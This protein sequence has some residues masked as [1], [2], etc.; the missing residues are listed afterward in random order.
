MAVS[1]PTGPAP[2]TTAPTSLTGSD[3]ATDSVDAGFCSKG[4]QSTT[5]RREPTPLQEMPDA[6]TRLLVEHGIDTHICKRTDA[7]RPPLSGRTGRRAAPGVRFHD[8]RPEPAVPPSTP[9]RHPRPAAGDPTASEAT[10]GDACKGLHRLAS[11]VGRRPAAIRT[12]RR[13]TPYSS[14]RGRCHRPRRRD[15]WRGRRTV[16]GRGPA[17]VRRCRSP[18]CTGGP[19][20]LDPSIGR[21]DPEFAVSGRHREDA[22]QRQRTTPPPRRAPGGPALAGRVIL[23]F[24]GPVDGWTTKL[25]DHDA[26]PTPRP[27]RPSA[28]QTRPCAQDS[29]TPSPE[30]TLT[31]HSRRDEA[32]TPRAVPPRADTPATRPAMG[33]RR[34]GE[35][36]TAPAR[37]DTILGDLVFLLRFAFGRY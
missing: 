31:H 25:P 18:I 10:S 8:L 22:R 20:E 6:A 4:A 36:D 7:I 28:L 30:V 32:A 1:S 35:A 9:P 29:V 37:R 21:G 17:P 2:T 11:R 14:R 33:S 16:D 13:E 34:A 24:G 5:T 27:H 3:L 26:S 15:R 19:E 23:S 12:L